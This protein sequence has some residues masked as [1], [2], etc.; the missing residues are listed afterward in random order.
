MSAR[1]IGTAADPLI[2]GE[3]IAWE[4]VSRLDVGCIIVRESSV[5]HARA[6]M[7]VRGE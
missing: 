3:V 2:A 7:P 5:R 4:D 1:L 6:S